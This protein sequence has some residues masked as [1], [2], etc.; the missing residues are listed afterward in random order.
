M[1]TLLCSFDPVIGWRSVGSVVNTSLKVSVIDI[2]G[3]K[4]LAIPSLEHIRAGRFVNPAK[5][6]V[7]CVREVT[8]HV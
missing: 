1:R 6:A 7:D 2:C 8:P 3:I 5:I 4:V